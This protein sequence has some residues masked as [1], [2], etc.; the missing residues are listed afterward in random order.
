MAGGHDQASGTLAQGADTLSD[1]LE[2]LRLTGALFFLV[3]ASTPWAA[4]APSSEQLAPAILPRARR[5]LVSRGERRRLLV[6]DARRGAASAG[7]R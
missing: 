3:D 7:A 2:A 5:R 1:V 4:A 6:R